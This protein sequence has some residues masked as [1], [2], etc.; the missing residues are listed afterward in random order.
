MADNQNHQLN[1]DQIRDLLSPYLDDE[2]TDEER[3]LVEQA[4]AASAELQGEL[5]TLRRTMALVAALPPVWTKNVAGAAGP[6]VTGTLAVG[7]AASAYGRI[8]VP[9]SLKK[10]PPV[11]V[12]S[13]ESLHLASSAFGSAPVRVRSVTFALSGPPAGHRVPF[14]PR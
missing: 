14:E 3:A 9:T 6:P 11:N 1:P 7:P 13:L 8:Q 4:L 5:E 2:V 10:F 12:M